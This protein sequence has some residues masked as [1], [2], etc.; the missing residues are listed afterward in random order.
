MALAKGGRA[1]TAIVA[2]ILTATD[3]QPRDVQ[4][5]DDGGDDGGLVIYPATQIMVDPAP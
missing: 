5:V 1:E 2:R 4:Q 3:P